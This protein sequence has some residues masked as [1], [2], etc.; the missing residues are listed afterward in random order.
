MI[1]KTFNQVGAGLVVDA[2]EVLVTVDSYSN[3]RLT[4]V[5][6]LRA[7]VLLEDIE[8]VGLHLVQVVGLCLLE[9]SILVDLSFLKFTLVVLC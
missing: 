5:T 4:G 2:L 8:L 6:C 7:E 3:R 1:H 9:V